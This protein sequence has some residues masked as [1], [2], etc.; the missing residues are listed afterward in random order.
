[1]LGKVGATPNRSWTNFQGLVCVA[2]YSGFIA[3]LV[4]MTA[5]AVSLFLTFKHKNWL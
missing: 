5:I 1:M 4:I 2:R 3:S